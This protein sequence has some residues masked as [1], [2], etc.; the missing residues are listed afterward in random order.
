LALHFSETSYKPGQLID[1]GN[2]L[3]PST[4][5]RREP[6]GIK[7]SGFAEHLEERLFNKLKAHLVI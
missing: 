1:I 7:V 3:K 6:N 4:C 5:V 2:G